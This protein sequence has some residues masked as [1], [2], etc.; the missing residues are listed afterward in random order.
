MKKKLK[1]SD[2]VTIILALAVLVIPHLVNDYYI[3][4]LTLVGVYVIGAQ[5]LNVLL[6][7]SGQI[8]IG[9][10]GF[11]AIGSYVAALTSNHW[12][13]FLPLNILA[14]AIVTGLVGYLLGYVCLRMKGPYLALSTIGFAVIVH[15]IAVN[16]LKVTGGP[17][18]I[19][20]FPALALGALTFQTPLMQ[21]Y[22]VLA[23]VAIVLL[24]VRNL[25]ESRT[26]RAMLAIKNDEIG[27]QLNGINVTH[28][29]VLAFV[30]SSVLAGICGGLL[31]N[32]TGTVFPEMYNIELSSLFIMILVIGGIGN[33]NGVTLGSFLLV[34]SFE[35][36]RGLREYQT[37]VYCLAVILCIIYLQGGIMGY[38][39]EKLQKRGLADRK[40]T[41]IPSKFTLHQ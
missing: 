32:L 21:Y 24:L 27:A 19:V 10:A 18:G 14:I 29:K 33:I 36:L 34:S 2:Y 11:I 31:A 4:V 12:S 41:T 7:F 8:S 30:I 3:Y 15:A 38:I 13:S 9:H 6:G 20:G 22:L 5:G 1:L 35:V 40:M 25:R 39:T 16:W 28:Y 37:I 17:E 26:G 23:V